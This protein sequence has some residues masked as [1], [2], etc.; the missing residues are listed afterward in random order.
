MLLQQ[1]DTNWIPIQHIF[2]AQQIDQSLFKQIS[3]HMIQAV[4]DLYHI[5]C[6]YNMDKMVLFTFDDTPF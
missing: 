1:Y 3:D 2:L 6:T 4:N 5:W